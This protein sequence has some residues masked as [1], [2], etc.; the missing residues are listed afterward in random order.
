[1]FAFARFFAARLISIKPCLG[2]LR[3]LHDPRDPGPD[4]YRD[5]RIDL[6]V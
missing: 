2:A 6:L 4:F 1:L 3:T 5:P